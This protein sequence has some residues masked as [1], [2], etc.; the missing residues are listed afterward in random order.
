MV[1]GGFR[2]FVKKVATLRN[3]F[4]FVPFFLWNVKEPTHLSKRVGHEVPGVVVWHHS[5]CSGGT[6]E[7]YLLH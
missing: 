2:G 5:F 6:C 1:R 4:N 3:D 7:Y